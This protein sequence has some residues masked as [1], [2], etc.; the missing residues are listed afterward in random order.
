M[1]ITAVI[2]RSAYRLFDL[3]ANGV[4]QISDGGDYLEQFFSVGE[5]IV[6]Y[7]GAEELSTRCAIT[8]LMMRSVNELLSTVSGEF[9]RTTGSP[10][11]L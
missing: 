4:M 7:R 8:L 2:I 10:N 5:E 11:Y 9:G 6:S 1:C 3:P